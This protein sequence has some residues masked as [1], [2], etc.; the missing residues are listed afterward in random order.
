MHASLI[1][2]Y[3]NV[4]NESSHMNESCHTIG[5]SEFV[6]DRVFF[7]DSVTKT[8]ALSDFERE[9]QQGVCDV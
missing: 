4:L 8:R 3:T 1:Y 9:L 2:K 7:S 5:L 6:T